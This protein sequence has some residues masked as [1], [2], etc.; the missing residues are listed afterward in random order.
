MV[1]IESF[2]IALRLRRRA[3]ALALETVGGTGEP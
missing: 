1:L 3:L 2:D